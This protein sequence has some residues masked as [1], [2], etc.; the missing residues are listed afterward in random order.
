[1]TAPVRLAPRPPPP[2]ISSP[3]LPIH[4]PALSVHCIHPPS[5][6][7]LGKWP[8][9]VSC[10]WRVCAAALFHLSSFFDYHQIV[11]ADHFSDKSII[12]GTKVLLSDWIQ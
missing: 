10:S 7:A 12:F 9:V 5:S 3:H 2:V 1:M 4:P 8:S 11:H 6:V